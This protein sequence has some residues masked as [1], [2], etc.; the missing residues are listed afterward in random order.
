M[1]HG[2]AVTVSGRV[3]SGIPCTPPRVK[4]EPLLTMTPSTAYDSGRPAMSFVCC[5][6]RENVRV[7]PLAST[8]LPKNG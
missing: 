7:R 4:P 6:I 1:L 8:R 3:S 2:F 5:I